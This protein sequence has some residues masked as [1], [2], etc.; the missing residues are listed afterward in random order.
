MMY[1]FRM[2]YVSIIIVYWQTRESFKDA[3]TPQLATEK[4]QQ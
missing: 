2:V 3:K 4:Q 1:S